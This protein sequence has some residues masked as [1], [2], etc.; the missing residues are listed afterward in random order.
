MKNKKNIEEFKEEYKK[1]INKSCKF[2]NLYDVYKTSGFFIP[3]FK[4]QI[5]NNFS[6]GYDQNQESCEK[7]EKE[8]DR[9]K[10]N[11][12]FFINK[13]LKNNIEYLENIK[14]LKDIYLMIAHP[15]KSSNICMLVGEEYFNYY[16]D[17]KNKIFVENPIKDTEKKEII[18]IYEA[19]L[20]NFKKRLSKYFDKYSH[21]IKSDIYF[22]HD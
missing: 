2:E 10:I 4:N 18:N 7:A 15:G 5:E 22:R 17:S 8:A 9:I 19:Q 20:E 11:K 13:N 16:R 6:F 12:D 14:N 21:K 3:F 1:N